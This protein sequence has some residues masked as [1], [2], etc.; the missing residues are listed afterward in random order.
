MWSPE[1]NLVRRVLDVELKK[2]ALRLSAQKFGQ[3]K[4]I[5][6][7]IV[8][9][10]DQ[11]TPT[12]KRAARSGYQRLLKR[13]LEKQFPDLSCGPLSTA[14]D[15]NRSFSP[16]YTRGLMKKGRSA[17]A[18]LGVNA[19]ESQASVDAAL[20]FA[21]LWMD[22]CREREAPRAHVEG[23]KLF[24]PPAMSAVVRERMSNLNHAAAKFELFEL[25]EREQSMEQ[26]DCSDRGNIKTRLARCV[27]ESAARARFGEAIGK[28]LSLAPDTE[29]AVLSATE[30]AFPLTWAGICAGAHRGGEK[31]IPQCGGDH[32]R[33]WSV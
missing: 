16:V 6:I 9:D 18:V 25:N 32:L 17:F 26:L 23:L 15:L 31:L 4:P 12:A 30:I 24:V 20:T 10:R 21:I 3:T 19:Q 33:C 28:V 11:R 7:E 27:D 14:M 5:K 1:R 29:M 22:H 8:R 2:D 13:M